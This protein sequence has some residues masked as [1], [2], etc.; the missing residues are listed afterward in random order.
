MSPLDRWGFVAYNEYDRLEEACPS[1]L[2]FDKVPVYL[3]S[4]HDFLNP[5]H[6]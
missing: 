3:S 1:A 2:F 5:L 6:V 4:V